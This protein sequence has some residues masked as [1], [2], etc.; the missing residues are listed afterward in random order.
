MKTSRWAPPGAGLAGAALPWD[1]AL[2]QAPA[3]AGGTLRIGVTAAAVPP[4]NGQTDQGGEGQRFMA[5][6]AFDTISMA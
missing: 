5:R 3:G 2:A 6:T 4:P 1:I